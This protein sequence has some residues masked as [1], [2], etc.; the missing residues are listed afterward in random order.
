[1]PIASRARRA[2]AASLRKGLR[3]FLSPRHARTWNLD[4]AQI[5]WFDRQDALEQLENRRLREHLSE[6][7]AELLRRWI[8]DGYCVASGII[9]ADLIDSMLLDLDH[10]W[11]AEQPFDGLDFCDL[12]FGPG[13]PVAK[14]SHRDLLQLTA[15]ERLYARNHSNWRTSSFHNH[16]AGAT[17]IFN[18]QELKRLCSLILDRPAFPQG[19]KIF[20]H[21]LHAQGNECLWQNRRPVQ[22][23][24][25]GRFCRGTDLF[26]CFPFHPFPVEYCR[27]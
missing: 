7:D 10:S 14:T 19:S 25:A 15:A 11:T 8:T 20:R 1:M 9:P 2:I 17:A 22:L 13:D 18:H 5:A 12:R 27:V 26:A 16:S 24:K 21:S 23:V 3:S 6:A 4:P